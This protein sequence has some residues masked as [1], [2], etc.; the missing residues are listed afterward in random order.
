VDEFEVSENN[1]HGNHHHAAKADRQTL[2]Q[3]AHCGLQIRF[4]DEFRN[5]LSD[6]LSH[7]TGLLRRPPG[8]AHDGP[9]QF[10]PGAAASSRRANFRVSKGIAMIGASAVLGEHHTGEMER[11]A[12]QRSPGR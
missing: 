11:A 8:Y 6:G 7:I 2:F 9:A 5:R 12:D 1:T 3:I 4:G 10:S